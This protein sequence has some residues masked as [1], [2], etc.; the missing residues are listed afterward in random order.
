MGATIHMD[1]YDNIRNKKVR[2]ILGCYFIAM[3]RFK[4]IM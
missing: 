1:G 3:N 2:D 4:L